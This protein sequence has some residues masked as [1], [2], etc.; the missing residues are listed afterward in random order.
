MKAFLK[1]NVQKLIIHNSR[2]RYHTGFLFVYS[3]RTQFNM[4]ENKETK[5]VNF[6]TDDGEEIPFFVVEETKIAGENYLL[7]TDSE[8]EE[9]DAYILREVSE[10]TEESFYEMLEDDE[11][12]NA[13]SKVFAELLDDVEFEN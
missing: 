13:I 11:K 9:A 6:T 7:V 1:I 12:I 2:F 8:D 3:E 4:E 10:N 5:V